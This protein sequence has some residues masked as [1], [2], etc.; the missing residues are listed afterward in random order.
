VY[1][2]FV[3]DSVI[4]GRVSHVGIELKVEFV[5]VVVRGAGTGVIVVGGG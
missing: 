5:V 4:P 1:V 3:Q 2:G